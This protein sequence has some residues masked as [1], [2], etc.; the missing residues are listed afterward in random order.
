MIMHLHSLDF[1]AQFCLLRERAPQGNFLYRQKVTKDLP[2]GDAEC[3]APACQAAL[4]W[5]PLLARA[6]G[7]FYI[8]SV[9]K[10]CG[11][12]AATLCDIEVR[13]RPFNN[14]A[15][16][17]RGKGRT[18]D[19][20]GNRVRIAFQSFPDIGSVLRR[21]TFCADRKSPKTC[22]GETLSVTLPR[23]KPLSPEHPSGR[24]LGLHCTSYRL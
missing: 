8:F 10:W 16:P 23:A 14:L 13:I 2:G 19:K 11:G 4:P 20:A 7:S 22:P 21:V 18:E 15:V 3:H 12:Y 17:E 9:V 24:A 6:R 5:G 1:L